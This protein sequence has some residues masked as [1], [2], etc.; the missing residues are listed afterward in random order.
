MDGRL[1][2]ALGMGGEVKA[3]SSASDEGDVVVCCVHAGFH[4][5]EGGKPVGVV[6]A[7]AADG[8]GTAHD[9][10]AL[11]WGEH[12][13]IGKELGASLVLPLYGLGKGMDDEHLAVAQ[14]RSP[15]K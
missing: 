8:L 11:E 12:V 6:A 2:A 4:A 1:A 13:G 9:G 5:V 7:M 10:E 14:G 15:G 3:V